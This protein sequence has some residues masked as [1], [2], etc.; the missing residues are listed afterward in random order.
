M[1]K[2]NLTD[3]STIECEIGTI[4]GE[5]NSFDIKNWWVVNKPIH[6]DFIKHIISKNL[7]KHF[8]LSI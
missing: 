1:T 6:E 3:S 8:R 7:L 4:H 5:F 2:E